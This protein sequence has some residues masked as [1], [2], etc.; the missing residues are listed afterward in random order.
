MRH[1][2]LRGK[3]MH[4]QSRSETLY[5]EDGLL[6]VN[7][8]GKV[9]AFAAYNELH[10]DYP[11]ESITF[12]AP[13]QLLI[14]GLVDCHVH[15]PQLPVI[16]RQE[17]NLLRWLEKH[18]YPTELKFSEY[19]YAEN[20]SQW[21]FQELLNHGTTTAAVFLTSSP[22]AVDIAF[23][24]AL[25]T[26]NRAIMGLSLMEKN[27]PSALCHSTGTL[28]SETERLCSRWHHAAQDRLLYAWMPRYALSC[29][30]TLLDGIG[31]LR[32]RYP[33]VYLHTHLSE[34]IVEIESVLK[35]FPDA[36]NYTD[37]YLKAGLLGPKTIFAHG[38][39]LSDQELHILRHH[40]CG[41]AHCPGSNFFLKSG[42]F[43][44]Q[45]IQQA[46]IPFGLGSDVGAG[47]DLSLL[48]VMK[49]AQYMQSDWMVPMQELFY[50]A[51]LGG[52]EALSLSDRIGNFERGK[53]ADFLI[54][55]LSANAMIRLSDTP[56]TEELLSALIYQGDDRL[57]SEVYI[58]GKSVK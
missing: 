2:V 43:R 11:E 9:E 5:L 56:T 28:L 35:A 17:D 15:L 8:S 42:R 1:T 12:L 37:V 3:I 25:H 30:M 52:A 14:P 13:H 49:D 47:P 29:S 55:D 32:R 21:F 48:T 26:G 22:H 45:R 44:W 27:A 23:E 58:A 57:V 20:I 51:T 54:M 36:K 33:D 6:A 39:H 7:E 16:G 53:D 50:R 38:I 19:S 40:T 24:A 18:I 46:G 41:L 31:A 10:R 34:Q 4:A